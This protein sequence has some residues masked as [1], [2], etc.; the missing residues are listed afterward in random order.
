MLQPLATLTGQLLNLL[1][2]IYIFLVLREEKGGGGEAKTKNW[3]QY[4]NVF[5]KSTEQ[6]ATVIFLKLLAALLFIKA[7]LLILLTLFAARVHC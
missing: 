2:F 3:M 4:L 5:N 6:K 7:S 1:L